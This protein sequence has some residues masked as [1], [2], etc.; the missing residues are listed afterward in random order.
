MVSGLAIIG[1]TALSVPFILS[2]NPSE[3]VDAQLPRID[4]SSLELGGFKIVRNPSLSKFHDGIVWSILLI[5]KRNGEVKAWTIPT[6]N[7]VVLM[8][9]LHWWR[10][11]TP[12]AKFGPSLISGLI[13]E[14]APIQCHDKSVPEWWADKWLWS[15]NGKNHSGQVSDMMQTKGVV[16][17]GYFVVGKSS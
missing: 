3:R 10:P 15:I 14:E 6:R 8:P 16:E 2:L 1:I 4:L 13:D 12:C 7:N 5:R 9:D 17:N 11:M